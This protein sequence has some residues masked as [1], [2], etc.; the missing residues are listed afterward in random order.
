V[1][2]IASEDEQAIV[3]F[4][5]AWTLTISNIR[6][7]KREPLRP[8]QVHDLARSEEFRSGRRDEGRMVTGEPKAVAERLHQ[9][10]EL[11]QADEIVVVTPNLDRDRRK[12]SYA[13][14]ADAWR[15]TS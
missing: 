5:A 15:S 6:R 14:L 2:A 8:E 12:A 3:D 10:K 4:E 13:A 11:A 9:M 7:G 1:L